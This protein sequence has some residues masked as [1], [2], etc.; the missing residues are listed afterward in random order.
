MKQFLLFICLILP[1]YGLADAEHLAPS[2]KAIGYRKNELTSFST[3]PAST[4]T[5][6]ASGT[7]WQY[8]VTATDP[9]PAW[10][11]NP[12]YNATNPPWYA[13]PSPLGYGGQGASGSL[14]TSEGGTCVDQCVSS[15][16]TTPSCKTCSAKSITTYFRKTVNLSAVSGSTFS[17]RY[18]RDDGLVIYINGT[19]VIRENLPA[20]PA[21]ISYTTL[22][23]AFPSDPDEVAWVTVDPVRYNSLLT[24]GQNV[25]AAEVHQYTT[26]SSDIRFNMELIQTLPASGDFTTGAVWQY[27]VASS[28]PASGWK[29][30]LLFNDT[31]PPWY[32]G[33]SPL[34]YGGQ[35]DAIPP[36]TVPPTVVDEEGTC[37]DECAS[38]TLT[39]PSCKTC[40]TKEITTYFRKKINLT[41]VASS[42]ITL[43]YQ[44]DDGILI[45]I[46]GTERVRE[47]LPA[48]TITH[49]TPATP[50]P[51][52][53]EELTWITVPVASGWFCRGPEP[54]CGRNT[55]GLNDQFGYTLQYGTA[56]NPK[57][58]C[59]YAGSVSANGNLHRGNHPVANQHPHNRQDN[60]RPVNE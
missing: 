49:T 14:I 30:D 52:N 50:I 20:S 35:G 57:Y 44:R 60:L 17:L 58:R 7:L 13:G 28:A 41:N 48:G 19:E 56:S 27:L 31:S 42:T 21:P 18:Q 11:S 37:V 25:I 5:I 12:A 16:P 47:G 54:D 6:L 2:P 32:N 24:E 55:S 33:P 40:T 4:T 23:T 59:Y 3:S 1:D 53:A 34:G 29:N 38:A 43:R 39:T 15:P 46:N 22:A 8:L 10:K 9:D 45:Y 26:T 36:A 51:T